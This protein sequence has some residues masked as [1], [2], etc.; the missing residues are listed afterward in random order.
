MANIPG[1]RR[2]VSQEVLLKVVADGAEHGRVEQVGREAQQVVVQPLDNAANGQ[3]E[4]DAPGEH[5]G[6]VGKAVAVRVAVSKVLPV[7]QERGKHQRAK[8]DRH[9]GEGVRVDQPN[10]HNL[11]LGRGR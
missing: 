2:R 8:P 9:Q 6:D 10:D 1:P 7:A 5:I 3:T 11:C 4:R